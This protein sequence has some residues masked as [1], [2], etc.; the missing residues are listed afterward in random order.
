MTKVNMDKVKNGLEN[1]PAV[2]SGG[3]PIEALISK[4]GTRKRF[5]DVL[6]KKAAGFLSSVLSAY[7]TNS[8]LQECEPA[9]VLSSAMVAATLDLPINANLGFAYIVPY[10]GKATFQMGWK[11]FVQL[12]MRSGLYKTINVTEVRKGQL[13][14]YN[15][16]TGEMEFVVT[17]DDDNEVVGYVAYERLLNGF[18]KY[19]Y[20]TKA[21]TE[22]HAK[23]FSQSYKK[24]Y[25]VWVDDFDSM[26]KKT[27]IKALLSKW[28]VLSIEM[29][30]AIEFDQAAVVDDKPVYLDN[31]DKIVEATAE[32]IEGESASGLAGEEGPNRDK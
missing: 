14:S 30:K 24:G 3:S 18:E 5:S 4:E 21:D 19:V 31:G 27:V 29:Q 13:K 17:T 9:T 6:G 26:A 15:P 23:K 22:R 12:A 1:A 8:A 2:T 20:M 10:K 28:G 16:F 25:G 32:P 7:N 11:G